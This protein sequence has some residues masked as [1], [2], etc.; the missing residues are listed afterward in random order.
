MNFHLFFVRVLN[1]GVT[2]LGHE[3]MHAFDSTGIQYDTNGNWHKD[4]WSG[5]KKEYNKR[6]KSLIDQ[7]SKFYMLEIKSYVRKF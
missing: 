2:D 1:F 4:D 7:Y 5:I 3:F 6:T